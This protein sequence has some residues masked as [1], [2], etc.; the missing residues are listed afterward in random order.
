MTPAIRALTLYRGCTFS[1]VA[2]AKDADQVVVNLSGWTALA[3]VREGPN[4]PLVLDLAPTIPTPANGQI[5]I[6]FT[7]EQTRD[8]PRGS[9][10][11]SLLLERPTGE[12]LGPFITGSFFIKSQVTRP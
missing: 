9:Y 4:K 11:W 10:E 1:F 8:L 6:G 7:D 5:V 3:Q 2:V 12:I